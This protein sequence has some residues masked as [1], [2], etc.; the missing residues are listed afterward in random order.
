MNME[1]ER[2]VTRAA[3][4][5]EELGVV[6]GYLRS[7]ASSP[8]GA[9]A[10]GRAVIDTAALHDLIEGL[11]STDEVVELTASFANGLSARGDQLLAATDTDEH[12][13]RRLLGDLRTAGELLG[14]TGLA[15]WCRLRA[16]DPP[17]ASDSA[18]RTLI[19]DTRRALT[20]WRLALLD[21]PLP[22]T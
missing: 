8:D 5:T 21:T 22:R 6:L 19:D 16:S 4:L 10:A 14:A 13:A 7:A 20:V 2:A 18:M 12:L 11:G 15:G 3:E 1:M 17:A 9:S